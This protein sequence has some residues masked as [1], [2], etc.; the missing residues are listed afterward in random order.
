MIQDFLEALGSDMVSDTNP[1]SPNLGYTIV[2]SS[3]GFATQGHAS[4][5]ALPVII[6]SFVLAVEVSS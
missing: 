2:R 5:V 6:P 1:A 3:E 4:S